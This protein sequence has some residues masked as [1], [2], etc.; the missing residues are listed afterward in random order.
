MECNRRPNKDKD[1]FKKK[2]RPYWKIGF[3]FK[4]ADNHP[5]LHAT[6]AGSTWEGQWRLSNSHSKWS[7]LSKL[8]TGRRGSTKISLLIL[9]LASRHLPKHHCDGFPCRA[10]GGSL[11]EQHWRR[12]AVRCRAVVFSFWPWTGGGG[13]LWRRRHGK[14]CLDL[15]DFLPL[16]GFW[17]RNTRI[18][19]RSTTCKYHKNTLGF[20][21][22][23]SKIMSMIIRVVMSITS[24][25]TIWVFFPPQ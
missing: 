10:S 25:C 11:Q 23:I 22:Y 3:R 13:R 5:V 19:I 4:I 18:T 20:D 7:V 15:N 1:D 12:C 8:L 21:I 16:P 9:S 6:H 2:N 24:C 14:V 17:T